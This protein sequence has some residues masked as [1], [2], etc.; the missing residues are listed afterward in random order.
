MERA[1]ALSINSETMGKRRKV[2]FNADWYEV[3]NGYPDEI[4]LEVYDAM[5]RYAY[6]GIVT[7]SLS[8]VSSMAFSF[9][10]KEMDTNEQKQI[11][12]FE[13]RSVAAKKAVQTR[14]NRVN[15]VRQETPVKEQ[16]PEPLPAAPQQTEIFT[17]VED[18]AAEKPKKKITRFIPPTL[19]EVNAYL[20]DKGILDIDA[21]RF[22]LFYESKG[23]MIGKNKMKS[24]KAAVGT[25]VRSQKE[26]YN[27]NQRKES[28]SSKQDANNYAMQRYLD[29][30]KAAEEGV[31]DEGP[32]PF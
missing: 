1:T 28:V 23:W 18:A 24:W 32:E 27:G 14:W 2:L 4:R 20:H 10:K 31:Y 11:E 26:K 15:E 3:L 5:M 13:R 25:W 30:R 7:A 22:V 21:E 12:K 9:I 8:P 17:P 16:I 19:E 29:R 6:S